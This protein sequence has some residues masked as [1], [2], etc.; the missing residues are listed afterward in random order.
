MP[1]MGSL[2]Q[3]ASSMRNNW[4]K[5]HLN[6]GLALGDQ[7]YS[8]REGGNTDAAIECYHLALEILTEESMFQNWALTQLKI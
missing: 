3:D 8:D 4:V 2:H 5:T 6:I 1:S 7:I